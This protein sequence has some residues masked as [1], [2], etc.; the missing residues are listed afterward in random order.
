MAAVLACGPD[1]V[2]SHESAAALWEIARQRGGETHVAVPNRISRVREGIVIHRRAALDVTRRQGIPTTTV[3]TTLVDLAATSDQLEAAINEADKRDLIDPE[4]LRN[5]LDD[6]P[7]LQ[8]TLTAVRE[9]LN[10]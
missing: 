4:R 9:R 10:G 3:V 6:I 1:A 2:L 5:T 8:T 7:P